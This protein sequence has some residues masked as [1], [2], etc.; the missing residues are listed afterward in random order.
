MRKRRGFN[1]EDGLLV[2][3]L[4]R[5]GSLRGTPGRA[6]VCPFRFIRQT[7]RKIVG[8]DSGAPLRTQAEDEEM[9]RRAGAFMG[10]RGEEQNTGE[11]GE[12]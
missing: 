11:G 2:N 10:H 6:Y 7:G 8:I 12:G 3:A 9:S 4:G 5:E 1:V